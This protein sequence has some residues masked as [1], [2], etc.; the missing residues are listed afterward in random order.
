MLSL[1]Q[2]HGYLIQVLGVISYPIVLIVLIDLGFAFRTSGAWGITDGADEV[3]TMVQSVYQAVAQ[4]FGKDDVDITT[5]AV[6]DPLLSCYPQSVIPR[7][8]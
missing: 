2:R 4:S 6:V 7:P 1:L 3:I 5:N 8:C